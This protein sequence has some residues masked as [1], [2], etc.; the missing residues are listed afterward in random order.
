MI[1]L[2]TSRDDIALGQLMF[3]AIHAEP[4]P[5]SKAQ[6]TAWLAE[7]NA[8][9]GWSDRLAAQTVFVHV[10]NVQITGFMT[11]DG[12][13]YIDFAFVGHSARGQG[14][15]RALYAATEALAHE[16]GHPEL[17]THASLMAQGPFSKMGFEIVHREVVER[18]GQAL[19][20]AYMRKPLS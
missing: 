1:R 12:E 10:E 14:V 13:G 20:R 16:R 5:Y 18:H 17:S 2:A 7:P 8:G 9:S 19:E 15:F 11:L 4:S 3:D 6:R